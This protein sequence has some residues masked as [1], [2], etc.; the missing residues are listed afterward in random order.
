MRILIAED[1]RSSRRLLAV[2]LT[3]AG[4]EVTA[5]EDGL[6]AWEALQREGLRLVITDWLMPEMNGPELI[7]RI[8]AEVQTGYVYTILVTAL[9][10]KARVLEGLAAGA[11]DYLPKPYYAEE[12]IARVKIGE[13][14]LALEDNLRDVQAQV[15]Y[16]AMHDS[17]TGLLNRRAIDEHAHAEVSRAV[18]SGQPIGLILMDIDHFKAVNDR[19]G[20]VAGD[21]ALRMC[22]QVIK[23]SVRPYDWVGRWGGEEFLCILP[24]AGASESG[25]AAERVREA[26]ERASLS[27]DGPAELKITISV[28]AAS[29]SGAAG[30][31]RWEALVSAADGALYQAKGLG[32]NRVVVAS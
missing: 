9:E 32:R 24:G 18:R 28:G 16:Q 14:I 26:V 29:A 4:Y 22:S 31:I 27:L 1:E 3:T 7:R 20:H 5:V 25:R 15:E 21:G 19:Y 12:L 8:R 11:D 13:R 30:P 6:Q 2:N 17:L 10:D 23:E